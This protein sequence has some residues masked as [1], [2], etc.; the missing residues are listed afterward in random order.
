MF[1]HKYKP[2]FDYSYTGVT[3]GFSL[4]E[5]LIVIVVAAIIGVIALPSF[6]Q[7]IHN[8]KVEST[9]D[10]L[11]QSF[12]SARSA[13]IKSGLPVIM[14]ASANETSCG[15]TW[16]DGWLVFIDQNRDGLADSGDDIVTRSVND[17]LVSIAVE[18]AADLAVSSVSFNFRGAPNTALDI[19]LSRGNE[20]AAMSISPFGK[21]L[22]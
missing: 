17:D 6:E 8:E 10:E 12:V 2:V 20:E 19:T 4:I 16:S 7:F 13:A 1:K 3:A 11:A 21:P 5:L 9:T 14:C 18:T 15:G 22:R